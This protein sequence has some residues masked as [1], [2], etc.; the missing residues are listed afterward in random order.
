MAF[1][2]ASRMPFPDKDSYWA[3]NFVYGVS[4]GTSSLVT[5]VAR[6][7]GGVVYE[8]YKGAKKTGVK[9]G[10]KGFFM[11]LGGLCYRPAKGGFDFVA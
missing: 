6:G 2:R 8:P 1:M 11:G 9:G 10:I 7:V 5:G 4:M 3:P